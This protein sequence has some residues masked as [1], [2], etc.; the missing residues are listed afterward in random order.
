MENNN[1]VKKP[2]MR[3]VCMNLSNTCSAK[4]G[5]ECKMVGSKCVFQSILPCNQCTG[6]KKTKL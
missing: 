3:L 5:S 6:N 4:K 2:I 1:D